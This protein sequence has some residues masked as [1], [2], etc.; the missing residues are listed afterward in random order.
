MWLVSR[1][2]VML[3]KKKISVAAS[4]GYAAW[5]RMAG[6]LKAS[7]NVWYYSI[8]ESWDWICEIGGGF[9]QDGVVEDE[10]NG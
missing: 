8:V 4:R 3:M 10:A 1:A 6:W 2:E 5:Q 7:S 9:V